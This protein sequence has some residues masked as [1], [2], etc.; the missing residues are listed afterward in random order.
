MCEGIVRGEVSMGG[1]ERREAGVKEEW[2]EFSFTHE[3]I[4]IVVGALTDR[5]P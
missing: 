4:F 1:G 3:T 5:I 2:R